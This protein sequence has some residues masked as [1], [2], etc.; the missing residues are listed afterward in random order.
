[1]AAPTLRINDNDDDDEE[2]SDDRCSASAMVWEKY[3]AVINNR[4]S[5][6]AIDLVSRVAIAAKSVSNDMNGRGQ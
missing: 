1:M 5:E 3:N 2:E 6:I 4:N